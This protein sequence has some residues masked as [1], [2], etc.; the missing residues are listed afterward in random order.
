MASASSPSAPRRST[1]SASRSRSTSPSAGTASV[2]TD[3]SQGVEVVARWR[4]RG[5]AC[6]RRRRGAASTARDCQDEQCHERPA[7]DGH[8]PSMGQYRRGSARLAGPARASSRR[9]AS[10]AAPCGPTSSSCRPCRPWASCRR[11]SSQVPCRASRR[12]SGCGVDAEHSTQRHRPMTTRN[13][14]CV[15]RH[16]SS[17]ERAAC[18]RAP[19]RSHSWNIGVLSADLERQ[20]AQCSPPWRSC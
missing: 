4:G 18:P 5:R 7:G 13:R 1:A 6:R 10:G 8:P 12:S 9:R 14:I 16:V 11:S 3:G 17:M 19:N 15:A 20:P 2:A